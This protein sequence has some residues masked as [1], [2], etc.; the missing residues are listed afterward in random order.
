MN[1]QSIAVIDSGFGG[2]S[3]LHNLVKNFPNEHFIYLGDNDN[4]PYGNLSKTNLLRLAI[5]SI[6]LVKGY[7]IKGIVLACNTLSVNLFME[8]K[9]YSGL[10]TFCTFPPVEK[11]ELENKSTLL[12][13]TERTAKNYKTLDNLKVVGLKD[14]ALIIEK[15]ILDLEEFNFSDYFATI[16]K[17]NN[18]KGHYETVVLGCTHYNFVKNQIFVH[19]RPQNFYDGTENLINVM[20]KVFQT[21][22]SLLNYNK[23]GTLFIG[24]NAKLNEY[25]YNVSGQYMKN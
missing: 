1:N 16:E 25:I 2:L 19:F 10:P 17:E 3:V 13:A 23:F 21:Q 11:C 20:K 7:N 18:L 24:N 8:I 14:L 5:K 22:K 4:A 15:N 12:L 6:D 9:E